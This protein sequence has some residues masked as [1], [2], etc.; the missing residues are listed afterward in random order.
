MS[1]D[2][3][4]VEALLQ[5]YV[6]DTDPSTKKG[7]R[8]GAILDA[9]AE[10][11]SSRGYRATSMDELAA[12]V[13]V[14]KGTLYLYFPKKVDLVIA[15]GARE[16]LAWMPRLR[17]IMEGGDRPA[18]V[19]LKQWIVSVL[20]L[21]TESPLMTRIMEEGV[22]EIVAD[23]PPELLA[24][25]QA[26]AGELLG[27]LL[28]KVAGGEHRWS[29]VELMD[30]VHVV[31]SLGQLGSVIRHDWARPGMSAERYAMILADLVVDGLRVRGPE[32]TL[33]DGT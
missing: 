5:R 6:G 16:K 28:A 20:L 15:C 9:A 18:H 10:M 31:G 29:P 22:E 1:V 8:R 14:A 13:G 25:S 17:D 4:E 19:R 32:R 24:A 27:P 26:M 30:R 7:R 12:T 33:E 11:F 2:M 3:D 21:P 23:Y